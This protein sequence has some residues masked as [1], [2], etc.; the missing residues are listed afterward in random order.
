ME[1]HSLLSRVIVGLKRKPLKLFTNIFI[2]YGTSWAILEPI[3]GII[4]HSAQYF[5]GEI[6]FVALLFFS[7]CIGLYKSAVPNQICIKYGNSSIAVIFGDLFSFDGFKV[8]PVSRF[9]FETQVVL[10]SLQ[11]KLIQIF[12]QSNEG[13]DGLVLYEQSLSI[14]LQQVNYEEKYRDATRQEERY[15]SLGTTAT[16]DLNGQNYMLFALAE[17][18][19]KGYIPSNN[20]DIFKML[21]ALETF[22]KEA[23]IQSRGRSINIPLIGSGV[24]GI[25]LN[26]TRLL[27]LNL[28]AIAN[29]IEEDG[30][31]T[32]EEVRVILHPK[33]MQDINL[34]DFESMWS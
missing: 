21:I 15:Y 13:V 12:I 10:T 14:A 18:E 32:T 3:I 26:S 16:L 27:E 28:L 20:C 5:S 25:R 8:I 24:T 7:V 6:K 9:F 19:L 11:S 34:S 4:P 1:S 30:K 22:W 23:R 31:I 33:Y 2:V 17:T 29:A